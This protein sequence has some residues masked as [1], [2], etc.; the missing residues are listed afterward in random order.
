MYVGNVSTVGAPS[1]TRETVRLDMR[2]VP[3]ETEMTHG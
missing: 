3:G 2:G 1:Y